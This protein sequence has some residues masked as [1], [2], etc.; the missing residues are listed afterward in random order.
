LSPTPLFPWE[1]Q[2]FYSL[3]L[4]VSLSE[5]KEITQQIKKEFNWKPYQDTLRGNEKTNI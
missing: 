3:A 4:S 5:S 2:E 1:Q